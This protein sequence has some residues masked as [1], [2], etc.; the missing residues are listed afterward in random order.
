MKILF[1]GGSNTVISGGYVDTLLKILKENLHLT[2]ED[3]V[4][5]AVGANSSVHGLEIAK[6]YEGLE[7]FDLVFVEYIINDYKLSN[8]NGFDTW[9]ASYE[10]LIRLMTEKNRHA[11]IFSVIFGRRDETAAAREARL[12]DG[13]ERISRAYGTDVIDVDGFL[14]KHVTKNGEEFLSLYADGAH[15][16]RRIVTGLIGSYVANCV[17]GALARPEIARRNPP[18]MSLFDWNFHDAEVLS[19][20]ERLDT[21]QVTFRNSKFSLEKVVKLDHG[22]RYS[23]LM[24]SS[25]ILIVFVSA[26]DSGILSVMEGG[27]RLVVFPT[28][29]S[30]VL[31]GEFAFLIKSAVFTRND[32]K[33]K[34]KHSGPREVE[35]RVLNAAEFES[36]SARKLKDHNMIPPPAHNEKP[37]VYLSTSLNF[38]V[39]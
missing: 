4:N 33:D 12:R 8:D 1:L 7:A 31:N 6:R 39:R 23:A 11:H 35:F 17:A 36:V 18:A 20:A 24:P 38:S 32:W 29:H 27:E 34:N 26:P 10:A 30:R 2:I 28:L 19:F 21:Q 14:K 15:Y 16:K 37:S 3:V 9:L 13:I 25:F 5:L 22:V